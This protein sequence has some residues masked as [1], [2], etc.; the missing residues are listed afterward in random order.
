MEWKDVQFDLVKYRAFTQAAASGDKERISRAE[1]EWRDSA[2]VEVPVL[3][4][5]TASRRFVPIQDNLAAWLEPYAGWSG[6]VCPPNL[7]KLLAR[8]RKAAGIKNWPVNALRHSFASYHLA[9]F[10]DAAALALE[11]GH[12]NAVLLFKHYR[13]LVRPESAAKYWNI[14][15]EPQTNLIELSA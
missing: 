1:K 7:R 2:L 12:T 9:A 6:N 15:P 5:K 11:L 13:Q 10:K 8:D 4:S 3:K 14:R